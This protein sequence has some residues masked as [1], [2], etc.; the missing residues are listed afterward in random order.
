MKKGGKAT[1]EDAAKEM[2]SGRAA[3][4]HL[5][6]DHLHSAIAVSESARDRICRHY[7]D[8]LFDD[9]NDAKQREVLTQFVV[10]E[11]KKKGPQTNRTYPTP[12]APAAGPS[13]M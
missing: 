2:D 12:E 10:A 9:V 8:C 6:F 5:V 7:V 13:L 3:A 11:S 4:M 1:R